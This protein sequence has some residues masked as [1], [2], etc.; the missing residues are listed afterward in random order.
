MTPTNGIRPHCYK[1]FRMPSLPVFE[2][3]LV[4]HKNIGRICFL[5]WNVAVCKII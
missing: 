1:L 5:G 4:W 3:P 2:T